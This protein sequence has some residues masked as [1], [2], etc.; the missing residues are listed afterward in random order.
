MRILN[1]YSTE[2]LAVT[3]SSER[4][5]TAIAARGADSEKLQQLRPVT[6]HL[7]TDPQGL[8]STG[9]SPKKWQRSIRS[10]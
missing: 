3:V 1:W 7:K 9:S 5:K 10:T 4:Y 6:F 8:F 2:K